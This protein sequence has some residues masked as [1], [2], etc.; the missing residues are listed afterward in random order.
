M[1]PPRGP[2][3]QYIYRLL[4]LAS[5]VHENS[6]QAI[7][8]PLL[9]EAKGPRPRDMPEPLEERP[10]YMKRRARQLIMQAARI[11][12]V[13]A[14]MLDDNKR[15]EIENLRAEA[16]GLLS[17]RMLKMMD[18][19]RAATRP[20]TQYTKAAA[21]AAPGEPLPQYTRAL[22]KTLLMLNVS[23]D[24]AKRIVL[25]DT[26]TGETGKGKKGVKGMDTGSGK[27]EKSAGS[28]KGGMKGQKGGGK[29]LKG[30]KQ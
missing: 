11:A 29:F 3:L 23:P 12:E 8:R 1:A 7:A 26:G 17:M 18:M 2:L 13:G 9:D 4:Y 30:K 21:G 10:S 24:I 19:E 28:G 20:A 27:G 15:R 14:S 5:A 22:L 6:L 16:E 25:V